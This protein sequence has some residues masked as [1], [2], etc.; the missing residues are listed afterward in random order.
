MDRY[1]SE[2]SAKSRSVVFLDIEFP[3]SLVWHCVK[4]VVESYTIYL[5][6]LIQRD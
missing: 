2:L 6:I 3:M 5:K 4:N 1:S